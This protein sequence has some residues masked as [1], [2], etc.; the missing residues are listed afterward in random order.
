VIS[1][2]GGKFLEGS[3]TVK[4]IEEKAKNSAIMPKTIKGL[5]FKLKLKGKVRGRSLGKLPAELSHREKPEK[6][7]PRR[8]EEAKNW[9]ERRHSPQVFGGRSPESK[10][11]G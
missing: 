8:G 5:V 3:I 9:N 4:R 6:N 2:W 7:F 10:Y 1:G 11:L